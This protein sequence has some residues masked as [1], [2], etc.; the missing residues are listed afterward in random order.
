MFSTSS[1]AASFSWTARVKVLRWL[2]K[3]PKS[4]GCGDPVFSPDGQKIVFIAATGGNRGNLYLMD[5]DGA[6]LTRLTSGPDWDRRPCFSPDGQRVYFIRHAGDGGYPT[7]D[8]PYAESWESDVYRV[9][10]AAKKVQRSDP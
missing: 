3:K 5:K 7:T 2:V 8:R 4:G 6:N 1:S 9:D 10:L